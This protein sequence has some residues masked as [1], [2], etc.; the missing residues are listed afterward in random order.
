MPSPAPSPLQNLID[1]AKKDLAQNLAI[2]A[3]EITVMDARAVTW[4][5]AS[6]G[7]PQEGYAYAQV[8]TPG[9]LIVLEHAS[10]QYEYHAGKGTELVHCT[11][12]LPPVPGDPGNT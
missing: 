3:V 5:D 8:L 1:L 7:C 10:N 6:L 4:S 9:Y 11:N 2:P 12:P